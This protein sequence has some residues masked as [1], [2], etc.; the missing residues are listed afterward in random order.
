MLN[1][2][3]YTEQLVKIANSYEDSIS[4]QLNKD[5]FEL[6]VQWTATPHKHVT[7]LCSKLREAADIIDSLRFDVHSLGKELSYVT[8]DKED[9]EKEIRVLEQELN[10]LN[11][12]IWALEQEKR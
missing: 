7:D 5:A 1:S 10:L 3:E 8:H 12:E 6:A 9:L 4:N 2:P 11:K